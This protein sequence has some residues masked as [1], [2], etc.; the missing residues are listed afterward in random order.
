[1]IELLLFSFNYY[2]ALTKYKTLV[3]KVNGLP[4]STKYKPGVS[5]AP[6]GHIYWV[7]SMEQSSHLPRI[8]RPML[9]STLRTAWCLLSDGDVFFAKPISSHFWP[10]E[11][12]LL[13]P[14][15]KPWP[16]PTVLGRSMGPLSERSTT[17]RESRCMI[18]ES[19]LPFL[20]RSLNSVP[21][22][23]GKCIPS[24]RVSR[25]DVYPKW[26][27]IPRGECIPGG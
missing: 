17:C 19:P 4:S 7:V 6:T 15:I 8:E 22:Y 16:Q 14:C 3:G 1:M 25:V 23:D 21:L 10:L 24:G 13:N 9:I 18:S 20:A 12:R 27:C 2:Y 11:G 26:T 5:K